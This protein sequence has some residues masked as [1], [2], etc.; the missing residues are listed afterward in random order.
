M[1]NLFLSNRLQCFV[2]SSALLSMM[3]VYDP[4]RNKELRI[5]D[6]AHNQSVAIYL[7]TTYSS[8]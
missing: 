7:L 6:L 5:S 8:Q 2:H 3:Y 1:Y 4:Y